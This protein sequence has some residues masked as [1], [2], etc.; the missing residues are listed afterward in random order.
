MILGA[1]RRKALQGHRC[2]SLA[3]L[4]RS[5]ELTHPVPLL[6]DHL[7]VKRP[8]G[9]VHQ[10]SKGRIV[11]VDI[12]SVEALLLNASNAWAESLSQH[13]E[14][15]K[16]DLGVAVRVRV[17]L[18]EIQVAFVV[19]EPIEHE[20]GVE[21]GAF[22]RQVVERSI[23]VGDERV[24]LKGEIAEAGTVRGPLRKR[25]ITYDKPPAVV[26]KCLK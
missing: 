2:R 7:G 10:G 11:P 26:V 6:G 18:F 4:Q 20:G 8:V 3:R 23:G 13:C 16:V 22:N 21:V 24:E 14:C 17:V 19:K 15:S 25:N 12:Q 5:V 1:A 9:P